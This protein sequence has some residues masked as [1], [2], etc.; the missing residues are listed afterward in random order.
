MTGIFHLA[1]APILVINDVRPHLVLVAVV[2]VTTLFG[3]QLG[4]VWAFAAGV[5]VTLLGYE[6]LGS[7]PLALLA[8][9]AAV[10]VGARAFGRVAW[11]YAPAAALLGSFLVDGLMLLTF[12][13]TGTDLRLDDPLALMVSAAIFNAVLTALFFLPARIVAR[14]LTAEELPPW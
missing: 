5:T 3:F 13:L 14:R 8:L 2:L 4:L 9:C 12:R 6:P 10:A 11:V 1:L 7:T